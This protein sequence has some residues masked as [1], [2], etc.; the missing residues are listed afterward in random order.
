MWFM[1][2][3]SNLIDTLVQG[4]HYVTVSECGAIKCYAPNLLYTNLTES[5]NEI[6]IIKI[7]TFTSTHMW[8]MIIT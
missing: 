5:L 2:T 1:I 8:Y 4:G 7:N 6:S 3:S